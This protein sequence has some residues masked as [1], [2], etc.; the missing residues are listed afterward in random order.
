[1]ALTDYK[2]TG[3]DIG[4]KGITAAPDKLS[5]T[6]AENKALFDR[7]VRE[8]VAE[9]MNGLIDA[10]VTEL[11]GKMAAPG[12]EGVPGQYLRIGENGM[13]WG[14]PAGGGDMV[15]AIYDPDGDGKVKTADTADSCNGNAATATK[16]K[17]ARTLRVQDAS[18]SNSG[19]A[20]SFDGS[21]NVLLPLPSKIKANIEGDVSGNVTGNVTGS[22][23]S[24]TGNAATATKL[25]TARTIT[26]QDADGSNKGSAKSF[27]G[28]GNVLLPLPSKIKASIMGDVSGNV[29]G[30][31]TGSSGSCT[32]N[33]ATATK[34]KTAR[35]LTIKDSTNTYSGGSVSF[36]GSGNIV[37]KLPSTINITK[38]IAGS[39]L[40]GTS[41]PSSPVE[42]QIFFLEE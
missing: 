16:L 1:M 39:G 15:A 30:N 8:I 41:Y 20:K 27:D 10:V 36:D 2:I 35:T 24:C 25:Q 12:A 28:S 3:E 17:T 6:A 7:L 19:T 14:V 38:L 34:L 23:G 42:G 11:A 33:A 31:V 18:G 9:K 26:V 37:L 5:G 32:G 40:A 13:E 4:S 21:G 22:S 29:S